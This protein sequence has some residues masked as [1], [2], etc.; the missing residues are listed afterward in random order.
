M[1]GAGVAM[2]ST[3]PLPH[4]FTDRRPPAAALPPPERCARPWMAAGLPVELA[5]IVVGT[6]VAGYAIWAAQTEAA[7][8]GAPVWWQE[9]RG[10][11]A[12]EYMPIK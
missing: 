3:W 10:A 5:A 9:G 4:C 11:P 2:G 8:R 6:A 1:V 12:V 7:R